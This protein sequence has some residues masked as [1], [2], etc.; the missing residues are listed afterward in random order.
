MDRA[1]R[2]LDVLMLYRC[3]ECTLLRVQKEGETCEECKASM[4]Q[5]RENSTGWLINP[6]RAHQPWASAP[7]KT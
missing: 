6:A 4:P 7:P 5:P 3:K 2:I 1:V